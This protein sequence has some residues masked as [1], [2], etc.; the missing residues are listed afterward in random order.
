ML[1]DNEENV[2]KQALKNHILLN[3]FKEFWEGAK[4]AIS[5]K[6]I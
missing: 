6:D 2:A 4:S 3:G 1:Q 5:K